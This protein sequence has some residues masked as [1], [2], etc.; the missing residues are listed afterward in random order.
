M[1]LS[2]ATTLLDRIFADLDDAFAPRLQVRHAPQAVRPALD[3]F[4]FED[5]FELHADLPGLS[6]KDIDVQFEDGALCIRG[7]RSLAVPEG[8]RALRRERGATRFARSLAL[9]DDVDVERIQATMRDGVLR[10][11]LPKSE[12]ARPRQIPVAVN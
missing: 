12:R 8:G 11:T 3:L 6:E 5:R 2:A 10:I 7:E 4:E 9:G 1:A